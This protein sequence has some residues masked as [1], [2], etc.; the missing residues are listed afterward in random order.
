MITI[1]SRFK[2]MITK[3]LIIFLMIIITCILMDLYCPEELNFV[4]LTLK[5]NTALVASIRW[6]L[7]ILLICLW[8]KLTNAL[9]KHY[10]I[11]TEIIAYWQGERFRIGVWLIL[12]ELFVCENIVIQLFNLV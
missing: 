6:G 7:I 2:G 11:P 5:R 8:P 12:F 9:G 1:I 3:K 10:K 4:I